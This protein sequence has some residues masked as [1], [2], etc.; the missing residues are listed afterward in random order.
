[1]VNIV[2]VSHGNLAQELVRTAEMICGKA[3]KV[4]PVSIDQDEPPACFEDRMKTVMETIEGEET[5]ILV[6]II[7]GTPSNNSA[8]YVLD[9][10]VEC[11][12]GANLPMLIDA[13]MNR[14]DFSVSELADSIVKTGINSV[15]SIKT[16]RTNVRF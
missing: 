1:M 8:R 15:K 13:V 11:V 7:G 10:N 12:T 4:Y 6:D 2:M 9:D 3:D 16:L 5:L 14:K